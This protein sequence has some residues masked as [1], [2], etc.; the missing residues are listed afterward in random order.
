MAIKETTEY[1]IHD[2]MNAPIIKNKQFV[3]KNERKLI[4]NPSPPVKWK[5][6]V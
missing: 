1:G 6:T 3:E 4:D 2:A 5:T